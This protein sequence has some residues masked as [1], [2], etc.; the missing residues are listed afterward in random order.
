MDVVGLAKTMNLTT[1]IPL[2]E[3]TAIIFSGDKF[4]D[5]FLGS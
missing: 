1:D 2:T 3:V 4:V 5:R